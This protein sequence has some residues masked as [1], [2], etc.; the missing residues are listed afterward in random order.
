MY[1]SYFQPVSSTLDEQMI[2]DDSIVLDHCLYCQRKRLEI[3]HRYSFVQMYVVCIDACPQ[4]N[5]RRL[6]NSL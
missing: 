6:S 3:F 2:Q 4:P 5:D 1:L